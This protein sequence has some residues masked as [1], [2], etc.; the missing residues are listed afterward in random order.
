[1]NQGRRVRMGPLGSSSFSLLV[2]DTCAVLTSQ[3]PL[4][5]RF[6][7]GRGVA[8]PWGAVWPQGQPGWTLNSGAGLPGLGSFPAWIRKCLRP[9]CVWLR[10]RADGLPSGL[11]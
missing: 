11:H 5:S 9:P 10:H 4:Q 3:L 7:A 8:W 2:C 1:M 6:R